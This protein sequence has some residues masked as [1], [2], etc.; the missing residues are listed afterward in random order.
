MQLTIGLWQL[1]LE[2]VLPTEGEVATM[3][4]SAAAHWQQ[5]LQ[6]IGYQ[7]AYVDLFQ[8]LRAKRVL[9]TLPEALQVLDCGIGAGALSLALAQVYGDN[10]HIDGVDL[11]PGMAA[12]AA[13]LL[14]A[15]G[16][17]ATLHVRHVQALGFATAQFDL[18]MAAHLLEHV[19]DPTAAIQEMVRVLKPGGLML[20]ILSQPCW[21]TRL[22][23]V[24]RRFAMHR[25]SMVLDALKSNGLSSISIHSL[26]G[27]L[28]QRGS[29]AY[30]GTRVQ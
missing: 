21:W 26:P 7:D 11:S 16:V 8:R 15:A 3:Y 17:P 30:M 22:L 6:R 12:T 19:A 5:R 18:V 24:Y 27:L 29:R 28:P 20:L 14:D 2:R 1:R 10:L 25:K 9:T 23:Q 4:D 13:Q